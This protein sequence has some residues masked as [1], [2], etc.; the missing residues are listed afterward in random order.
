MWSGKGKVKN[1]AQVVIW[2]DRVDNELTTWDRKYGEKK[3][4]LFWVEW[5]ERSVKVEW[6]EF[7]MLGGYPGD[8]THGQLNIHLEIGGD[9]GARDENRVGRSWNHKSA[10]NQL[11]RNYRGSVREGSRQ[12][13]R[14]ILMLQGLAKKG[15]SGMKVGKSNHVINGPWWGR[16]IQGL[17]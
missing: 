4:L 3:N 12:K 7:Q 15:T 9:E 10:W 1:N 16:G 2:W 6:V 5:V 8:N 13:D 14:D 11:R 17:G